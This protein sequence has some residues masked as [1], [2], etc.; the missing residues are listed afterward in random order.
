MVIKSYTG[1]CLTYT[2]F[3]LLTVTTGYKSRSHSPLEK[4]ESH[5]VWSERRALTLLGAVQDIFDP[6]PKRKIPASSVREKLR[7]PR[8]PTPSKGYSCRA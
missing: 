4:P 2:A 1:G 5:Q 8:S 7:V 6:L 3:L